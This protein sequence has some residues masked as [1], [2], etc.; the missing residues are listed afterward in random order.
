[1]K[2]ATIEIVASSAEIEIRGNKITV[3]P[4]PI[5]ALLPLFGNI[6]KKITI[7]EITVELLKSMHDKVSDCCNLTK[8]QIANLKDSE[9]VL[10]LEKAIELDPDVLKK[11]MELLERVGILKQSK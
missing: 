7:G 3:Y 8:E 6:D 2:D 11:N 5:G 9:K 1:M 10:I 4:I